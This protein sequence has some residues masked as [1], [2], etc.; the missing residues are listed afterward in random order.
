MSELSAA[1]L[2]QSYPALF[3]VYLFALVLGSLMLALTSDPYYD[4]AEQGMAA[5]NACARTLC[6]MDLAW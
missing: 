5:L 1:K 4:G 2:G 3:E 6:E